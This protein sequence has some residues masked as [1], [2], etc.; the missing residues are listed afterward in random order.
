MT[1]LSFPGIGRVSPGFI[2][3]LI[4]MAGR[5]RMD[6]NAIAAVMSRESG[7][8]AAIQNPHSHATGLIQF[9]P[10]T[11]RSLGTTVDALREMSDIEQLPYVEKFL[12][13]YAGRLK[14]RGD[15]YMAVFMPAFIGRSLDTVLQM[16]LGDRMVPFVAGEKPYEQ[17]KGLDLDKDGK[18]TVGDVHEAIERVWRKAGAPLPASPLGAGAGSV[19]SSPQPA[20]SA[21][22]PSS[23]PKKDEGDF[24]VALCGMCA[25]GCSQSQL[26]S[27]CPRCGG[28]IIKGEAALSPCLAY[29]SEEARA[30]WERSL[31]AGGIPFSPSASSV[32]VKGVES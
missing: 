3:A 15:Y 20:P 5:L 17:N 12:A 10:S 21:S 4:A 22:S 24:P 18:I 11:A 29:S 16:K 32:V 27:P 7:F 30:E 1:V 2:D 6:P 25:L 31:Q 8:Q 13:P 9:M 28:R 19:P 26:G 14:S 23:S